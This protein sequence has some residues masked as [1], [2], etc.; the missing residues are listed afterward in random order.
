LRTMLGASSHLPSAD[1]PAA[2]SSGGRKQPPWYNSWWLAS[3]FFAL[4]F[5]FWKIKNI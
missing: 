3:I 2:V 5:Y 1:N 4:V